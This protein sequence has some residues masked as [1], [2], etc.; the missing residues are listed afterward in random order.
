MTVHWGSDIDLME[1]VACGGVGEDQPHRV[2]PEG[3]HAASYISVVKT[4]NMLRSRF[5][6]VWVFASVVQVRW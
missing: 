3:L 6:L 1:D 2:G 5:V 4:C